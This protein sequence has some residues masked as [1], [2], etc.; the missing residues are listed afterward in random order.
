[1]NKKNFVIL[2]VAEAVA[3]LIAGVFLVK[4]LVSD[5]DMTL[6]PDSYVSDFATISDGDVI[7]RGDALP[8]GL[9]YPFMAMSTAY[10]DMP[11]GSYR[12]VIHYDTDADH[13]INLALD[14][15]YHESSLGRITYSGDTK[16][17]D[18]EIT[19]PSR[20]VRLEFSFNGGEALTVHDMTISRTAARE[21]RHLAEVV[22]ICALLDLFILLRKKKCFGDI[23]A[24]TAMTALVFAPFMVGMIHSG[25]DF[26]FHLNRL[27]GLYEEL[28]AGHFPVRLQSYWMDGYGYPVSIY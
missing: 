12:A 24:V 4:A 14:G 8:E 5:F 2:M 3:V 27:E 11:T 22:M 13:Y 21:R 15:P 6:A 28:A 23:V 7:I 19:H 20:D 18:F 25:H 1:M 10:M 17:Y 16:I 9:E 26:L